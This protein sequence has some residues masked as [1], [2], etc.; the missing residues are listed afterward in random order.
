MYNYDFSKNNEKVIYE[1]TN[2]VIEKDEKLGTKC[3]L[4]TNKNI[5]LFDNYNEGTAL[6]TR[7]LYMPPLYYVIFSEPLKKLNYQVIDNNT[8]LKDYNLIFYNLDL[9]AILKNS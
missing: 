8:Y 9:D 6:N 5:L 1:N 7:G 4:I 2:L 3:L